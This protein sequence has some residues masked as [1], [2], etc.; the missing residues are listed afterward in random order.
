M[1]KPILRAIIFDFNGV[2]ADDE[3][4]HY[5]A[6]ERVMG[7][8]GV[9]L[10]EERYLN[11]YLGLDDWGF[12]GAALRDAGLPTDKTRVD[13]LVEH[14]G[15]VY[16]E[17]AK[18]GLD[19]VPGA[20]PF[21]QLACEALPLAICSGA[22]RVEIEYILEQASL[23]DAFQLFVTADEM[24]NGKPHPEGYLTTLARLRAEVVGLETLQAEECVIFED[25][26][27]GVDAAH[28]AGIKC[29][30]LANS[31][32]REELK[33]ADAVIDTLVGFTMDRLKSLVGF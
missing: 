4:L 7:E 10:T 33:A 1:K 11:N 5:R 29:I 27:H 23:G 12:F 32:S 13:E 15:G 3:P 16:L 25:A 22:R 19:L 20:K 17:I 2:V 21:I 9:E 28:A 18:E 8:L 6:F 24:E 31:R 30:A 26:P 14:K